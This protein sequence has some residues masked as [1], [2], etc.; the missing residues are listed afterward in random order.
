[1]GV[2]VG[3]GWGVVGV[4]GGCGKGV[5]WRGV[6]GPVLATDTSSVTRTTFWF[7]A[8]QRLGK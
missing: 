4:C 3:C 1:M 7:G 5:L 8:G 2:W 6:V